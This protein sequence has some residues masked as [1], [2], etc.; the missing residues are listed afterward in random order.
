MRERGRLRRMSW[1]LSAQ[2]AGG[3]LA[4]LVVNQ[5]SQLLQGQ[6]IALA[7]DLKKFVYC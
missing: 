2:I 4:Q 5:G 3:Q 6:F 7:P 1:I